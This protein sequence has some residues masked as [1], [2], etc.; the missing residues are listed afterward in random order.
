MNEPLADTLPLRDLPINVGGEWRRGRGHAYQSLT[1]S[2]ELH[3]A[4]AEDAAEAVERAHDAFV[5]T[6]WAH[7][8]PHERAVVLHRIAE[9]IHTWREELAHLQR[10]DNGKPI[11]ETR[12]L[13]DNTYKQFS[14]STPFGGWRDSGI[15]RE[16]ERLGIPSTW[17]RRACTG[18]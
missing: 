7:R 14:I 15:G 1:V 17:N 9:A 16:K 6:N 4:S 5:K 2:A 10:R 12:A 18:A 8:K 3:A 11:T 13:V